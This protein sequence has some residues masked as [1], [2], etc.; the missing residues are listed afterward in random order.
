MCRAPV[1]LL[2]V[3]P[4]VF[5][6]D[7]ERDRH[8]IACLTRRREGLLGRCEL[9]IHLHVEGVAQDFGLLEVRDPE[10]LLDELPA[11]DRHKMKRH[12]A[13]VMPDASAP[14][15]MVCLRHWFH[16]LCIPLL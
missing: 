13:I 6:Q 3:G 12:P 7:C 16:A 5:R 14:L 1:D 4:Q 15:Q 10:R 8:D 11:D 9:H 2:D